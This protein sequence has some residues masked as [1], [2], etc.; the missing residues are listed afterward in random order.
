MMGVTFLRKA[1]VV[2]LL[3]PAASLL[4]EAQSQRMILFEEMSN[5]SCGPC[6]SQNPTYHAYITQHQDRFLPLAWRANFPGRDVMNADNKTMHD[7]RLLYYSITGVPHVRVNGLIAPLSPGWYDGAAADTA[8][9]SAQV[10][11]T[12]TTSP[13]TLTVT[14]SRAGLISTV[15]VNVSSTTAMTDQT[16][17]IAVVEAHHYY[18]SAG[19]N[20]E[21]DFYNVVRQLVP[22]NDG[23][24]LTLTANENKTVTQSFTIDAAKWNASQVYVVAFVQDNTT[25]EV[26]QAAASQFMPKVSLAVGTPTNV[27][28]TE[29][30]PQTWNGTFR[31]SV[32]TPYVVKI[33]KHLLNGWNGTVMIGDRAVANGDTVTIASGADVTVATTITPDGVRAGMGRL[34]VELNNGHQRVDRTFQLFS[35]QA[36]VAIL[37]RDEGNVAIENNYI[38][39]F[40]GSTRNIVL[41]DKQSEPLFQLRDFQ[42]VGMEVGKGILYEED[43]TLLKNYMDVGGRVFLAG[44]E[45]A[46]GLV[47]TAA[48]A[49]GYYYDPAFVNNYLHAEYVGDGTATL[50]TVTGVA[51]DPITDG[52]SVKINSGV[53]NQDTPDQINPANGAVKICSYNGGTGAGIRFA[54]SK[55]RLVYLGFGLEGIGNLQQRTALLDKSITWLMGSMGVDRPMEA[56]GTSLNV[57][58]NPATGN[59]L[60]PFTLPRAS[61][62]SFELFDIRGERVAAIAEGNYEAG[63]SSLTFDAARFASGIYT[64]VMNTASGR[65][66]TKLSIAH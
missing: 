5:A 39:A 59:V 28:Q 33:D 15:D 42:V 1:V 46:W 20:G 45:I 61:H 38:D 23:T 22:G 29:S 63:A 44:A 13:I 55:L 65:T 41:L 52:L 4:L 14:E 60:V 36:E 6:A 3:L 49:R 47:D 24:P 9:Q 37:V 58:P 56:S 57:I 18:A 53:K 25:K 43:V 50:T 2:L 64:L 48:Q 66:A 34:A 62:A 17:Q 32:A 12:P 31:S 26:M 35:G 8:A 10:A 40:A 7:G 54:D 11:A 30:A 16:L 21:K 19:T 27:R 51:G